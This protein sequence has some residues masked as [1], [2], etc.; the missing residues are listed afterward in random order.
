MCGAYE[1][2]IKFSFYQCGALTSHNHQS[3]FSYRN[4]GLANNNVVYQ[5]CSKNRECKSVSGYIVKLNSQR[6]EIG[7]VTPVPF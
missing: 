4:E 5:E 3:F 6:T 1:L 7:G 2:M